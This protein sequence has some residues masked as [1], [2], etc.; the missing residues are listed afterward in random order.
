MLLNHPPVH[1]RFLVGITVMAA[2][3]TG[4]S[5]PANRESVELNIEFVEPQEFRLTGYL[6]APGLNES[7]G[8]A[9][10]RR[11]AGL[12]WTHNDSGDEAV[13]YLTNLKGED[14]GKLALEGA[15][16]RDWEDVTL[17]PCPTGGSDCL[18]I[19]DTGD[20]NQEH[21]RA[22][23]YVV[24]EPEAVPLEDNSSAQAW[25]INIHYPDR[26][27]NIEAIAASPEGD[28]WM[29]SKGLGDTAIFAF[30]VNRSDLTHETIHLKPLVRLDFDPAPALG[31]LVTG[32]AISPDGKTL[33][34]RTYTQI[35]FYE[36]VGDELRRTAAC[37]LGH[38]EPQGEGVDFLNDKLL[39]LT[40]ESETGNL[41]PISVVSCAGPS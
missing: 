25:Q 29:I 17:G 40:S 15:R 19:A 28:L 26:P 37:W 13:L 4:D 12:L 7:S 27:F 8:V 32:A 34:A 41:A 33:V 22:R 30:K 9:A 5:P 16:A 24:R 11:H 21:S 1:R 38:R 20:N 18:Y 39:V 3:E 23:I 10:S 36:I 31:Q 14:L 35:F 2:C 6:Q